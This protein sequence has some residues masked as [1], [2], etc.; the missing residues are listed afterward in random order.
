MRL[1]NR[2]KD[3]VYP[4]DRPYV[5]QP[6]KFKPKKL[7]IDLNEETYTVLKE[8][9]KLEMTSHKTGICRRAILHYCKMRL[10]NKELY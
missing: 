2:N 4:Q 8:V 10:K 7:I 3:F 1:L 9:M 6:P 5:E